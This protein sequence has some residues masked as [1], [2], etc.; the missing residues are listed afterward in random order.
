MKRVE[1]QHRVTE[2]EASPLLG[3]IVG[4]SRS[5]TEWLS[6]CLNTHPDVA[7]IGETS[8]W[9]RKY[10]PPASDGT[11]HDSQLEQVKNFQSGGAPTTEAT[12]HLY[13][14]K[15][16]VSREIDEYQ[17]AGINPTPE[18]LFCNLCLHVASRENKSFVIEKTPHHVRYIDKISRLYPMSRFVIMSRGPYSFMLSYKHQGDR[19]RGEASV[20]F[21]KLYHPIG[22]ALIYRGYV[23][24]IIR[25]LDCVGSRGLHVDM[26]D[27]LSE[28]CSTIEKVELFFGLDNLSQTL[29]A[30]NSSFPEA[31]RP[32]LSP[33][34]RFWINILAGREIKKIGYR[35][36]KVRASNIEVLKSL[37]KLLPWIFGMLNKFYKIQ[38]IRSLVYLSNW[39]K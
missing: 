20:G 16:I 24:S 10:V 17:R 8:Y 2:V 5:G 37:L 19:M 15:G 22:C 18:R 38:G 30:A 12:K 14:K 26:D 25:G 32:E 33:V 27:I 9:G 3:F 31:K 28:P 6:L 4:M 13:G 29:A 39:L 11:Y 35:M 36:Q 21:G 23:R 7:V 1:E 34:D